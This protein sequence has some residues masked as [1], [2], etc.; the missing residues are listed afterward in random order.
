MSSGRRPR[1]IACIVSFDGGLGL[2]WYGVEAIRVSSGAEGV[3]GRGGLRGW[4]HASPKQG[5]RE[6]WAWRA[7]VK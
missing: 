1:G 3:R 4:S 2:R 7:M 6:D 5:I